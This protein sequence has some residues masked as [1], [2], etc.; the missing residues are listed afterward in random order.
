MPLIN[1]EIEIDLSWSKE[2]IIPEISITP[3]IAGNPRARPP[4]QAREARQTTG[5]TL[6]IDNDKLYVPVVTLS[7]NDNIKFLENIKQGFKRTI[8]WNKYKFEITT[9]PENNDLDDLI[10]P[11]FRNINRL[12]VLSF[13]NG[14]DDPTRNSLDRYY[15][16]LVVIKDFNALIDNKPLFDQPV[17]N[18]QK[19]Y[20][21]LIAMSKNGDYT[22]GNL[23]KY[24][25]HQKYYKLIGIDLSRKKCEYSSTN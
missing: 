6:Q 17:E 11:T 20:E 1:Y 2:C 25:N 13:K 19:A 10:D 22:S 18:K 23:L 3:A 7:I 8:S 5:A 24:L 16:L 21:K 14:N 9:Q 12:F 15:M 4:A